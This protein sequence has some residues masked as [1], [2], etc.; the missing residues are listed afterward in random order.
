MVWMTKGRKVG[1]HSALTGTLK[2]ETDNFVLD[3]ILHWELDLGTEPNFTRSGL[4]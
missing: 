1:Q 2:T 3:P 4:T